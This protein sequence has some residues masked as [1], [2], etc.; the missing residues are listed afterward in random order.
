MTESLQFP[1]ALRRPGAAAG[2]AKAEPAPSWAA[3]VQGALRRSRRI[4][5]TVAAVAGGIALVEAVALAVMAPLKTVVPYTILVDRQTGYV[6]TVNGI[7]PGALSQDQAV[8]ESFLVQYV[9]ARETFDQTDIRENYNKVTLW[10]AG[11]AR[12]EYVRDMARS[13][14]TSPLNIYSPATTLAITVKSVALLTPTTALVRFDATRR[15]PGA[16]SG[17]QRAYAA[18]MAFRYTGAPARAE[19]R[20]L[21]PLGFQVTRYRRDAETPAGAVVR[22][23]APQVAVAA[24]VLGTAVVAAP[25]LGTPIV[26]T[27]PAAQPPSVTVNVAPQP[28]PAPGTPASTVNPGAT[29]PNAVL[30]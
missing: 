30:Q 14:P 12:E 28:A 21:N 24:P 11:G 29:A 7:R 8:T 4:A 16:S 17:E 22:V 20:F 5:W 1:R 2:A 13:N 10:S 25:M 27:P 23:P 15:E 26:T 3:D 9:I 19:D 6:E 18:V